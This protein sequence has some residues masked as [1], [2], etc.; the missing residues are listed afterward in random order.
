MVNQLGL[1]Y[2]QFNYVNKYSVE[3]AK[4]TAKTF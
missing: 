2:K 3:N 4:I 1:I